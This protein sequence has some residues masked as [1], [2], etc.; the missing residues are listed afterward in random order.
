MALAQGPEAYPPR[1]GEHTEQ[2][3][4]KELGLDDAQLA[5]LRDAGVIN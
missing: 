2:V 1:I 4:R 3:L 5:A